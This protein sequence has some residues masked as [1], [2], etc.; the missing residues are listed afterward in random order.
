M[1][2][3]SELD[4]TAGLADRADDADYAATDAISARHVA[5]ATRHG[6]GTRLLKHHPA[7]S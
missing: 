4:V 2:A 1:I 5:A 6:S 3:G 7:A